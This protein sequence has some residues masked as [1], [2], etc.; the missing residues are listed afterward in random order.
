MDGTS[1]LRIANVNIMPG[2]SPWRFPMLY[3]L[4]KHGELP[5]RGKTHDVKVEADGSNFWASPTPYI[6]IQVP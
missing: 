2:G 4:L 3:F 5:L 1:R 6:N